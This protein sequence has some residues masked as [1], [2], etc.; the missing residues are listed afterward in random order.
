MTTFGFVIKQPQMYIFFDTETTGLPKNWN[1]SPSDVDNWP[2]VIQLAFIVFNKDKRPFL[3]YNRLIK[4]NGWEVPKEDFWIK[5]GFTQEK[6][7]NEGVPIEEA[8]GIFLKAYETCEIAVAHNM[9]YDFNILAAEMI[10]AG[11]KSEKRLKKECTMIQGTDLLKIPSPKGSGYKWP[12]LEEL[13]NFLFKEGFDGAHDALNDVM[14]T[15]KCY[16]EMNK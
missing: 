13:H 9:N 8:L 6:C 16:F 1:A 3:T 12:K 11:L 5:H 14:A 10:R 4:P 15:S 7:E 2:R